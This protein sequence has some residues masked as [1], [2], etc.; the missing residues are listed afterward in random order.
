MTVLKYILRKTALISAPVIPFISEAI[1][2]EIKLPEDPE[3]IHLEL[4]PEVSPGLID[5]NIE[6][7]MNKTREIVEL[8]HSLRQ[9]SAL[10]VRQPLAKMYCNYDFSDFDSEVIPIIMAELN[11][12][13]Y[14]KDE[15]NIEEPEKAQNHDLVVV[16]DK[17]IDQRLQDLGD[18]REITR[19]IQNMRKQAG[20]K[21][22]ALAQIKI[23]GDAEAIR[24]ITERSDE[25]KAATNLSSLEQVESADNAL[26]ISRGKL[27]FSL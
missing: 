3:S 19:L 22:N 14:A 8:G 5:K 21:P 7:V 26:E 13:Q 11:I 1:W 2:Q 12:E 17:K 4:W 18:L 20:L 25:V 10:K 15:S 6:N 9:K 24:F 16:I 23:S 27:Y